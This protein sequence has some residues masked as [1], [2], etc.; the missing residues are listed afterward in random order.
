MDEIIVGITFGSVVFL[1]GMMTGHLRSENQIILGN[2]YM[3]TC[4]DEGYTETFCFE[5]SKDE[6]IN[7]RD[8]IIQDRKS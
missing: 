2:I 4:L 3:S 1:L 8:E 6:L 5:K 7:R